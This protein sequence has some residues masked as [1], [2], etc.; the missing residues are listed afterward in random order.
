MEVESWQTISDTIN[1]LYWQCVTEFTCFKQSVI[2]YR[3]Q[4]ISEIGRPGLR[5]IKKHLVWFLRFTQVRLFVLNYEHS[6]KILCWFWLKNLI[7]ELSSQVLDIPWKIWKA[8]KVYRY[9]R[10][11]PYLIVLNKIIR[12]DGFCKY[13]LI[14]V[15]SLGKSIYYVNITTTT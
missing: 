13:N 11:Y 10:W 4:R 7:I 3:V 9:V 2:R 6:E 1:S 15:I 12:V 5:C 14:L 8:K